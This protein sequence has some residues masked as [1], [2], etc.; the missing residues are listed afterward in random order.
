MDLKTY[1]QITKPAE[2][3]ALAVACETSADYLYLASRGDRKVGPNLAKK[4]V[5]KERRLTLHE[6]R[7]DIWCADISESD[8][9]PQEPA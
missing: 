2:R 6:L 9:E 5:K 4:L 8:S 1:F 7:P 3:N